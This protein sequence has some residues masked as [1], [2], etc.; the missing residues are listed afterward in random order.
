MKLSNG[1]ADAITF[2]SNSLTFSVAQT[3][4]SA[5]WPSAETT[6]KSGETV[7]ISLEI[8][9]GDTDYV[10]VGDCYNID[11]TGTYT[12]TAGVSHDFS[13][14]VAGPVES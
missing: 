12:T 3:G 6:L 1:M 4:D 13:A 10:A 8:T 5:N 14:K 11:I 9:G 2:T 7:S